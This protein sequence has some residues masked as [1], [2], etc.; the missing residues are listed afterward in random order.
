MNGLF[1]IVWKEIR[2][3]LRDK[4]SLFFALLY[5]PL[6]MPAL[7]MAPLLV[8]ANKNVQDYDT[9]KVLH[10]YGSEKAPNLIQ[11]LRS[12][13]L[14]AKEVGAGYQE[15]IKSGDF[16][17][18]LEITDTYGEKLLTG[19]PAKVRLH[20]LEQ[21]QDSRNSFWQIKNEID[22]YS[23]SIASQRMMIRGFD[24]Q[25]LQPIDVVKN[26]LSEDEFG[27]SFLSKAI[28]F[29][30]IFSGMMGGFYLTTQQA[31][32]GFPDQGQVKTQ[33]L[34]VLIDQIKAGFARHTAGA[35]HIICLNRETCGTQQAFFVLMKPERGETSEAGTIAQH[36]AVDF[37]EILHIDPQWRARADK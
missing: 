7:M 16:K 2:D 25:L 5:G 13:N 14:D 11:H 3:N 8:T 30:A 29:L 32:R 24:Q 9:A 15:K 35:V 18:V 23:R 10:V 37:R 26:N 34:V 1:T 21:S 20:F 36:L 31:Q 19:D 28:V 6:L 33:A 17:V 12:R 4:R 22:A 27:T